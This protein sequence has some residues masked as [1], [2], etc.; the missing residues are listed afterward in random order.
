MKILF[1]WMLVLLFASPLYAQE[2]TTSVKAGAS[3]ANLH[4]KSV[5]NSTQ[6][7]VTGYGGVSFTIDFDK[8]VFFQP[9]VL[10]S[11]RGFRAP[12]TNYS[13]SGRVTFGYITVPL[14]LGYKPSKNF[15][16]FAGPGLGYLIRARSRFEGTDY[17]ILSA[18]GRRFNIDADA[19]IAWHI[20]P[21]LS[22]DARFSFGVTAL[23]RGVMTDQQGNEIGNFRDGYHRVL[24]LGFTLPL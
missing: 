24:M 11:I 13:L 1:S 18:V 7:R 3:F 9:E 10:Y 20:T 23:Y 2:I 19:G 5:D 8:P 14:L 21:G 12:A 22:M 6:G 16:L 15:S 17:D 4:Y